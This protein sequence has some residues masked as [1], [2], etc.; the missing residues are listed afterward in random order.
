MRGLVTERMGAYLS[1]T[2]TDLAADPVEMRKWLAER[3][4]LVMEMPDDAVLQCD[5]VTVTAAEV[6]LDL[7]SL[8]G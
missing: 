7:R 6:K 5:G 2:A 8:A 4:S 3:A 1:V